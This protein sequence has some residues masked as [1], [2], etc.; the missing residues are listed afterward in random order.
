M[1]K[2]G[3]GGG[4]T[5]EKTS[6]RKRKMARSRNSTKTGSATVVAIMAALAL[7]GVSAARPGMATDMSLNGAPEDGFV[8]RPNEIKIMP[9]HDR[10]E[11]YTLKQ[12]HEY[13]TDEELPSV[14]NWCNM[15]GTNYCTKNLN[16]HIPQYCGSCWAHGALSSFADRI[17]IARKA[18][19]IEINLAIQYI[20]NCGAN[21]AGSCHGGYHTGVYQLIQ[22]SGF[23]PYDTCQIYEACSAESS[24]GSCGFKQSDY[25]CTGQNVCRTCSTFKAMGGFC[26]EVDYFPN[27]TIAEYGSVRGE[28]AIQKEIYRRGPVAAVVNAQPLDEYTGGIIDLPNA[29]KQ[30]N[31]I[32]SITGW[33]ES[34]D[35]TPYWI[36][37]NSWGEYWGEM[38]YF[39]IKRGGDQLGIE[40]DCAWATPGS[41]T[42]HN[43]ACYEDGSNCVKKGEYLDP[44][45][46]FA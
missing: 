17:K 21:T 40:S 15:N 6:K 28:S 4:V 35:G 43:V 16:Q 25:T 38:G 2:K 37:R 24:E 45:H 3:K 27:A 41:W 1:G 5:E 31:H 7:T 20:L 10:R 33:G 23:V 12:P 11:S 30:P 32:V 29:S 46:Q 44:A 26:S 18:Q 34:K 8:G 39:R 14:W 13:T 22:D 36:V 9:G 42:E 19:G